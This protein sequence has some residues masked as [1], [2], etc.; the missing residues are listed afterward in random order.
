MGGCGDN[1]AAPKA[2][3]GVE[4]VELFPPRKSTAMPVLALEVGG[5]E[6][7]AK[8]GTIGIAPP[9]MA[10]L[11]LPEVLE[12]LEGRSLVAGENKIGLVVTG[13]I[14]PSSS[15]SS[16]ISPSSS[17]CFRCIDQDML[18]LMK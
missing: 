14:S 5:D 12:L 10:L 9:P 15:P 17:L 11:L 7:G 6:A 1:T 8:G 2:E 13:V 18:L 4:L 16:L 3:V